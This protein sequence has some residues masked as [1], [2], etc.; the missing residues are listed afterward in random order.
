MISKEPP[1]AG[2]RTKQQL[3]E[4]IDSEVYHILYLPRNWEKGKRYPVIVE[5][6]GNGPYKK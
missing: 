5:N 6:P 2:K 3:D 4:Y 1:E